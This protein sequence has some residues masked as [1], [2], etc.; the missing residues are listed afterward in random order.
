MGSI[1]LWESNRV[2]PFWILRISGN[3]IQGQYGTLVKY[4][5]SSFLDTEDIRKLNTG[6][7]WNFVKV[8]GFLLFG[9]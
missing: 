9:Y 4:Q 7:V 5:G 6:A 8:S 2:P 1:E 3:R